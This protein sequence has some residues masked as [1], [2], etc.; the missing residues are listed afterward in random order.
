MTNLYNVVTLQAL[1][2]IQ[3]LTTIRIDNSENIAYRC[4]ISEDVASR[5]LWR[6][7]KAGYLK[8]YKGP[9]GGYKLSDTALDQSLIDL[10]RV[11]GQDINYLG[12]VRASDRLVLFTER[13]FNITIREILKC[14]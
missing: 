8:A 13:A 12:G 7:R 4:G 2:M 6:L 1:N 10:L 3:H 11:M 14:E 9:Y 5:S